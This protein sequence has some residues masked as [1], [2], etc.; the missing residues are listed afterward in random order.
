MFCVLVS[1]VLVS[2]VKACEKAGNAQ[3]QLVRASNKAGL[4]RGED[5]WTGLMTKTDGQG[6]RE[7]SSGRQQPVPTYL[8]CLYG[9]L[10]SP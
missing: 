5:L 7:K 3:W 9:Y 6:R 4:G 8:T 2:L 10:S 1:R